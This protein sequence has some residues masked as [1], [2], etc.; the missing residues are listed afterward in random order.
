MERRHGLGLRA[1]IIV[2]LVG[3]F[4]LSFAALGVIVVQVTRRSAELERARRAHI[5]ASAL[6]IAFAEQPAQ[7][8]LAEAMSQRLGTS[9]VLGIA[10]RPVRGTALEVGDTR[11]PHTASVA[12]DDGDQLAV[13]LLPLDSDLDTPL[14]RLLRLYLM[15][16]GALIVL[17]TYVL[18]TRLIVRPVENLTRAS[19]RLAEGA[20]AP[21]VPVAGAAEVARLALSFNR[22]ASELRKQ[23]GALEQRLTELEQ[24]TTE[25]RAT[26]DQLVRSEKLASVGRLSAGVAH[27]IGNPLAAIS[28]LVEILQMGGLSTAEQDEFLARIRGETDRIHRIIRELLDYSRAR[29]SEPVPQSANLA[30]VIEEAVKLI[31]PQKDL[32]Q[33]T[34]ECRVHDDAPF[35]RAP[36]DELTQVVL[37]LL[38]NAAD[39]VNGEGTILVDLSRSDGR[40][41]LS[42]SDTGP[43]IAGTCWARCSIRSSPPSRL[44]RAP[45]LA[46][47][48][49]CRWSSASAARSTQ[50]TAP[51]AAHA[52]PSRCPPPEPR[53]TTQRARGTARFDALQLSDDPRARSQARQP[54]R[55]RPAS[56]CSSGKEASC[57]TWARRAACAAACAATSRT[58]AATRATSSR[59]VA[60]ADR[61][62]DAGGGHARKR[63][64]CSRTR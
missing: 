52:S 36:H 13:W 7:A 50:K 54:A 35:V 59:A 53:A 30:R 25:L 49:A 4:A 2:A 58:A 18:L 16:T 12:L 14:A 37:N 63:R 41:V 48:S 40:I 44:A 61:H 27:E 15:I 62:R 9:D 31:A 51:A 55:P 33:V 64:R 56:T 22:M 47:P 8:E 24:A 3:A 17:V 57:S 60:R 43:G 21:E 34:I 20:R 45:A 29:P 39:A 6:A 26:R 5:I 42:V 46:S 10:V 23:K 11:G 38:L 1:Q 32:R 19:E 28:G